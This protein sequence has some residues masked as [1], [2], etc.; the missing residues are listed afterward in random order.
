MNCGEFAQI[1]HEVAQT[2]VRSDNKTLSAA[3]AV[4]ARFH[5][6]TCES[7]AARLREAQGVARALRVVSEDSA[8]AAARP[9]AEMSLMD[10]FREHHRNQEHM[11]ERHRRSR[12]RWAEWMAVAAAAVALLAVGTWRFSRLYAN[13]L[14]SSQTQTNTSA[15]NTNPAAQ[16]DANL[17]GPD[18]MDAGFV[19]LPYGE[20]FSADDPGVVV[21]V[22]IMRDALE[23]LGYPVDEGR[24]DEVVQADLVVG[25][26]GWP[27]AVRLVQ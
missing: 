12:L 23:N 20:D 3:T 21:R 15:S 22:S 6:E 10:A 1:V 13:R 8:Q 11:R 26:D 19:P 4:S 16:S 24:G 27:R 14:N 18:A 2:E 17:Q 9:Y 25:E 5:A 7:C